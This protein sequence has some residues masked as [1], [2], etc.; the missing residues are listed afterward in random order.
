MRQKPIGIDL[1]GSVARRLRLAI[2]R[3]DLDGA[4]HRAL[5]GIMQSLLTRLLNQL[6]GAV[7]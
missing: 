3:I 5:F 6:V 7:L 1:V 4:V 2:L